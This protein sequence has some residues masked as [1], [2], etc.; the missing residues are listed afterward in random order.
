[1]RAWKW[2][3][4]GLAALAL[5]TAVVSCGSTGGGGGSKGDTSQDFILNSNNSGRFSLNVSPGTVD[6][7]KSDR[8]GLVAVLADSF[9]HGIQGVPITFTTDVGD[10]TFL[11]AASPQQP[12]VGVAVTDANGRADII[13]VAGVTPTGTGA[14]VGTGAIFAQTPSGFG[15]RAQVPITLLD[16]G[17]INADQLG[18]IPTSLDLVEPAPGQVLFFNIVGGT[19][20][21][22]LDNEVSG[23]GTAVLGQHCLPGCT[24][25]GGVLCIGSPCQMD[26]DCNLNGSSTPADVCVGPIRRCLASCAG[27]NCAG[28]R[29]NTDSDC[30]DGSSTPANVCKDSGQ[31]IAYIIAQN[32]AA[33]SHIFTV[34]DSAAGSVPVTVTVSF[35]CGNGVA[36]GDE[37]C[38]LGDLRNQTCDTLGHGTGI[39]SCNKDCTFDFTNCTFATPTPVGSG[40]GPTPGGP[41]GTSATRTPTPAPTF[42]PASTPTPGIGVPSNLT[43]AL[44]TNGSGD[45]GNGTLTT[46]ISA[47]VTD[48]L[49]N[50]VP[51]GTNVFY[52]ISGNTQGAAVNS[53]AGTNAA[54]PCDVSNFQTATG[55]TVLDQPG[56]ANTCVTYPRTSAGAQITLNAGSGAAADSQ[57][58]NLPPPPP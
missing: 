28:S 55:I 42:T 38:D 41:T 32:P 36:S 52:S 3:M 18:V 31:S 6:A 9:G 17:F 22:H 47:T 34:D 21:Y 48:S 43:L 7:N 29:C 44:L 16:V 15:L 13:A 33:G 40:G 51:D 5:A 20:P 12:T 14:I 45:N 27:E 8:I 53:P 57:T 54:P 25:N 50:P 24:E 2:T 4:G 30:N 39:L 11:P 35:I 26:S 56:V 1:M 23:I 58:F 19:P 49:G 37:Q 46:V 10:I